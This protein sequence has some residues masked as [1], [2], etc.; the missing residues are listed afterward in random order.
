MNFG[1]VRYSCKKNENFFSNRKVIAH[2]RHI[3]RDESKVCPPSLNSHSSTMLAPHR[4]S[5]NSSWLYLL[6]V[7]V[8]WCRI[9]VRAWRGQGHVHGAR[10]GGLQV[11]KTFKLVCSTDVSMNLQR[12]NAFCLFL[13]QLGCLN[14]FSE[15][16]KMDMRLPIL[17]RTRSPGNFFVLKRLTDCNRARELSRSIRGRNFVLRNM[18]RSVAMARQRTQNGSKAGTIHRED[19]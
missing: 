15:S 5:T 6:L 12:K 18:L 4:V 8:A 1:V 16:A 10:Y 11:S 3:S 9:S 2:P 7:C 19:F 14:D 17:A 13:I